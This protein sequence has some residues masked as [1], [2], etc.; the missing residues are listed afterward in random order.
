MLRDVTTRKTITGRVRIAD[1]M[2]LRMKGLIFADEKGF[3]YALVF[4]L[5]RETRA[6]ASVHMMF[7]PFP[8]DIVYL[9]AEKR[10]LEKATLVPW[11]L[12][13]TPKKAAKYFVELP[14]GLAG[15]VAV[16]NVLEW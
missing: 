1:T 2:L 11:M 3:D 5:P 9:D 4:V 12:N 7:V 16:G 15:G 10:V 6:G 13:Y 14:V 8:I